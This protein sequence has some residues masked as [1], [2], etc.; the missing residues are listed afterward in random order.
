M[1]GAACPGWLCGSSHVRGDSTWAWHLSRCRSLC[2]AGVR[3]HQAVPPS[4][5]S[6]RS[7]PH[8]T[9]WSEDQTVL[10]CRAVI[11][12]GVASAAPVVRRYHR[13]TARRPAPLARTGFPVPPSP[14]VTPAGRCRREKGLHPAQS[15]AVVVCAFIRGAIAARSSICF[16]KSHRSRPCRRVDLPGQESDIFLDGSPAGAERP[17]RRTGSAHTQATARVPP[18]SRP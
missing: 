12:P 11:S 6:G 10:S 17:R 9:V 7:A 2:L 14:A 8:A 5:G 1:P 13:E 18:D 4:A 3:E 15:R 16:T